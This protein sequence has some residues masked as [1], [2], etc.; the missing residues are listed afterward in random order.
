MP[1]RV[2]L[3]CER[4]ECARAE[5]ASA[6]S[7]GGDGC[8]AQ[9]HGDT[10]V[11]GL[12]FR[13]DRARR[14][15]TLLR[16]AAR[17]AVGVAIAVAVFG[18]AL[19]RFAS[20]EEVWH[21]TSHLGWRG[22]ALLAVAAA[23]NLVTYWLVWTAAV[24][25]LGLW[26]AALV[27]QAPTAVANTVPAGSYL[28][29][30]L[31]YTILRSFGQRPSSATLAMLVT[32]V[33]NNFAKLALP[34]VAL[35]A[36]AISGGAD[37]PRVVGAALGLGGLLAAAGLFAAAMRTD[38]AAARVG[39]VAATAATPLLRL[40]GRPA[41][42]GWDDALRRFRTRTRALLAARWH[43]LTAATLIS[44]LSLFGVLLASLRTAGVPATEV[45]PAEALAVFAF[46]RLGTAVPFSPGG[47]GVVEFA[48]TAGFVAAGGA[49]APVVAAVLVYRSL[50]YLLQI[51]LGGVAYLLWRRIARH[52]GARTEPPRPDPACPDP[53]PSAPVPTSD[54]GVAP[55]DDEHGGADYG[56]IGSSRR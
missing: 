51:P 40:V 4:S 42:R 33:W 9:P 48:L 52:D 23:W 20:P 19:P 7:P 17:G 49:R 13:A 46:A 8:G 37:A 21:A 2:L 26:R 38:E 6:S 36:L 18:F 15:P 5:G 53:P 14:S 22:V 24:P 27:A 56:S 47:V 3:T 43:L 41:P 39:Q 28:S 30:A 34:V 55:P 1:G 45:G 35:S 12:P 32:G 44:H 16:R 10:D 31:T 11:A 54:P 25:N 50:T 29:M